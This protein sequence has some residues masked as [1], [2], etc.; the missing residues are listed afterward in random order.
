MRIKVTVEAE[1]DHITGVFASKDEITDQIVDAIESADYGQWS[2]D[3]GGEYE[4][5]DWTVTVVES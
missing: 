1:V 3:N 2:G 5:S 4:T